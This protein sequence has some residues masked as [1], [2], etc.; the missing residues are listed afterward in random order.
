MIIPFFSPGEMLETL[1][2]CF[3]QNGQRLIPRMDT[4]PAYTL[5]TAICTRHIT[6]LHAN[7]NWEMP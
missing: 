3:H 6:Y 4:T 7:T 2:V 5:L 1:Y